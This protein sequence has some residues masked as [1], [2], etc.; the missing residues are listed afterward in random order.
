MVGVRVI[1]DGGGEATFGEGRAVGEEQGT[2]FLAVG[3]HH[4][5]RFKR[6]AAWAARLPIDPLPDGRDE[7]GGL[8]GGLLLLLVTE[9]ARVGG[10]RHQLQVQPA[11]RL[12]LGAELGAGA[13]LGELDDADGVAVVAFLCHQVVTGGPVGGGAIVAGKDVEVSGHVGLVELLPQ[14]GEGDL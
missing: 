3:V 1:P 7:F 9:N 14:H 5:A 8:F 6:H 10:T 2:A 11:C 13:S 12:V 4:L